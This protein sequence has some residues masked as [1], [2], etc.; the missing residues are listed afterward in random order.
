M[1][2]AIVVVVD[3]GDTQNSESR[4][5]DG[6]RGKDLW[7]GHPFSKDKQKQRPVGPVETPPVLKISEKKTLKIKPETWSCLILDEIFF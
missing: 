6:C 3:R 2:V 1:I 4:A 7:F 5:P